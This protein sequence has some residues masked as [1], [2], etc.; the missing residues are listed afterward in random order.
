MIAVRKETRKTLSFYKIR[1]ELCGH[2][3]ATVS[4]GNTTNMFSPEL[5][6]KRV[7]PLIIK[8]WQSS[9]LEAQ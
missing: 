8:E 1:A 4:S 2:R 5:N 7:V 6:R 9:P 3:S